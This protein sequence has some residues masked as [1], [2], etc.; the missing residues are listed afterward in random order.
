MF[1]KKKKGSG[2][3]P[4]D[5]ALLGETVSRQNSTPSVTF[6]RVEFCSAYLL[7]YDWPETRRPCDV[8][9]RDGGGVSSVGRGGVFKRS[10]REKDKRGRGL[11]MSR[12]KSIKEHVV[13]SGTAPS[14]IHV[15]SYSF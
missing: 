9:Q 12:T 6:P 10:W 8:G 11:F 13:N 1:S 4:L 14:N 15:L 3:T 2:W 7:S 5:A